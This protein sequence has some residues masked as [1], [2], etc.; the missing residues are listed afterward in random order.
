MFEVPSDIYFV[1]YNLYYVGQNNDLGVRAGSI[2]RNRG[3]IFHMHTGQRQHAC[4][5]VPDAT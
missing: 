1:V 3:S 4:F 5:Q 2:H